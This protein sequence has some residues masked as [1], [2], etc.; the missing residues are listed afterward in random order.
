MKILT[1]ILFTLISTTTFA[2]EQ[3]Q[4]ID[5][6]RITSQQLSDITNE[7]LDNDFSG[8]ICK[9][10]KEYRDKRIESVTKSAVQLS[11]HTHY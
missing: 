2:A 3:N 6:D 11:K 8:N 10:L 4:K 5:F 9:Q 7:C 1:A